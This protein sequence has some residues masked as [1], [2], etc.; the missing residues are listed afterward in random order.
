MHFE[1]AYIFPIA[2]P[3]MNYKK[4][5]HYAGN[6]HCQ[7]AKYEMYFCGMVISKVC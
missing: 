5:C 6:F 2:I 1:E 3:G 7:S 4:L